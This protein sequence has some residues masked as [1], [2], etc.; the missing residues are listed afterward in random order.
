M[1]PITQTNRVV[2]GAAGERGVFNAAQGDRFD[3]GARA[4]SQGRRCQI[5]GIIGSGNEL[6]APRSRGRAANNC[7]AAT[8]TTNVERVH[9]RTAGRFER[10]HTSERYRVGACFQIRIADFKIRIAGNFHSVGSTAPSKVVLPVHV[11][12]ER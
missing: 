10:F 1:S 12:L 11:K 4:N 3:R 6:I 8:P 9:C 5:Q 2:A 7:P